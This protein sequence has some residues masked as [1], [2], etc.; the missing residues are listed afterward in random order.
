MEIKVIN[1]VGRGIKIKRLHFRSRNY[2]L[3]LEFIILIAETLVD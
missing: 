2:H 1:I 3:L